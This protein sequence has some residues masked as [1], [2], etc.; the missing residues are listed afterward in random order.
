MNRSAQRPARTYPLSEMLL[1]RSSSRRALSQISA[2]CTS[3]ASTVAPERRV[4]G[5]NKYAPGQRTNV[6]TSSIYKSS[7]LIETKKRLKVSNNDRVRD[8]GALR[9][10]SIILPARGDRHRRSDRIEPSHPRQLPTEGNHSSA[11]EISPMRIASAIWV[12]AF[13][14]TMAGRPR[15]GRA[16]SMTLDSPKQKAGHMVRLFLIACC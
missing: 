4:L 11:A 12:M 16:N 14:A 15:G 13:L 5:Q 3:Q 2:T 1:L 9:R 6:C 8:A 10:C 7:Q